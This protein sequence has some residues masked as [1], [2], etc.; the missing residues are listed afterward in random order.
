MLQ[1]PRYHLSN[2]CTEHVAMWTCKSHRLH[3]HRKGSLTGEIQYPGTHIG[4]SLDCLILALQQVS[5][6]TPRQESPV[7]YRFPEHL[8]DKLTM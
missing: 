8:P 2:R 7:P 1:A 4:R 6:M 5:D 3:T